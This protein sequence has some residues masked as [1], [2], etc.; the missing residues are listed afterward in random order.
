MARTEAAL[1]GSFLTEGSNGIIAESH[2]GEW[3]VLGTSGGFMP[4]LLAKQL[5]SAP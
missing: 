1:G 2:P 3:A 4:Y 5:E